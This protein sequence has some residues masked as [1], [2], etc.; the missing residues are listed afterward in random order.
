MA[1]DIAGMGKDDV[2][3]GVEAPTDKA[4]SGGFFSSF[5]RLGLGAG[6]GGSMKPPMGT[7]PGMPT[8]TASPA[9]AYVAGVTGTEDVNVAATPAQTSEAP[10]D[11]NVPPPAPSYTS[12]LPG[13]KANWD[14][15]N[16]M[17]AEQN[18]LLGRMSYAPALETMPTYQPRE[19]NWK[20]FAG[21]AGLATMLAAALGK[22]SGA[23]MEGAMG[24]LGAALKGYAEGHMA[25]AENH[26]KDFYAQA[27]ATHM[28][29][30]EVLRQFDAA[31]KSAGNNMQ[32]LENKMLEVAQKNNWGIALDAYQKGGMPAMMESVNQMRK[33][34]GALLTNMIKTLG[35]LDKVKHLGTMKERDRQFAVTYTKMKE[36]GVQTSP[37]QDNTYNWI[38][39]EYGKERKIDRGDGVIEIEPG[40]DFKQMGLFV[41]PNY[42]GPEAINKQPPQAVA[43]AIQSRE[44][45]RT[46]LQ[47][48]KD[49]LSAA[50]PGQYPFRKA[51]EIAGLDQKAMQFER[52]SEGLR[53]HLRSAFF[54][55]S[56]AIS[57]YEQQI[58]DK[59]KP[60][61][62]ETQGRVKSKIA[63]TEKLLDAMERGDQKTWFKVIKD[64][65]KG[66]TVPTAKT[67]QDVLKAPEGTEMVDIDGNLFI[68]TK[69]L[70]ASIQAK[71][72][73]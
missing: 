55:G 26:R 19:F 68:V 23:G 12:D 71:G 69:D 53:I 35:Q 21:F 58:I 43:K 27:N 42:K 29:N 40:L 39:A 15:F 70:K 54:A 32:L 22:S 7:G 60:S 73:R 56:G 64:A 49:S 50:G 52:A 37:E 16:Q 46:V 2:N 34:N 66:M 11:H 4:P 72:V 47:D 45:M 41:P 13:F 1:Q 31:Q 28:R 38:A 9:D 17:Q 8:G 20:V 25:E 48:L 44:V 33:L 51:G 18:K 10:P 24:A 57:D 59:I 67:P 6:M 3:T 36:E 65:D 5:G 30:Q 63:Y 14:E 62:Y 61:L